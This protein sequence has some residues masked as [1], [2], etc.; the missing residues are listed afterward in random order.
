MIYKKKGRSLPCKICGLVYTDNIDPAI[1][2]DKG[3]CIICARCT[4][5]LVNAPPPEVEIIPQQLLTAIKDRKLTK[6]RKSLGLTQDA[7]AWRLGITARQLRSIEKNK[8]FPS[9]KVLRKFEKKIRQRIGLGGP[10]TGN[11]GVLTT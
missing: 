5:R 7:L 4:M 2:P 10:K 1:D 9:V 3:D 6:Y 8:Y 11:L